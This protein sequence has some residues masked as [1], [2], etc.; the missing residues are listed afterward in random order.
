MNKCFILQVILFAAIALFAQKNIITV[1][2]AV[3]SVFEGQSERFAVCQK[4]GETGIVSILTN[5]MDLE[6]ELPVNDTVLFPNNDG[7][8]NY[9]AYISVG[10]E[11]TSTHFQSVKLKFLNILNNH[12]IE[13]KYSIK[14]NYSGKWLDKG[15]VYSMGG[16]ISRLNGDQIKVDRVSS[17]TAAEV[18][19]DLKYCMNPVVQKLGSENV[20]VN[21]ELENLT[22]QDMLNVDAYQI[23]D[24]GIRIA[25]FSDDPRYVYYRSGNMPTLYDVKKMQGVAIPDISYKTPEYFG[26]YLKG[27][28]F[29]YFYDFYSIASVDKKNFIV[30]QVFR[31]PFNKEFMEILDSDNKFLYGVLYDKKDKARDYTKI[32]SFETRKNDYKTIP[33]PGRVQRVFL[34]DRK[35]G[36]LYL[37]NNVLVYTE[38]KLK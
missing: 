22:N 11:D 16:K 37:E 38:F 34:K 29:F 26:Y 14:A 8:G 6:K 28:K 4:D 27:D 19:S 20:K 1:K 21:I 23:K 31:N 32:F 24:D 12:V 33:L 30:D 7:F 9:L 17:I 3:T 10:V 18:S 15:R 5:K 36:Y 25:E 35:G 2:G 13:A